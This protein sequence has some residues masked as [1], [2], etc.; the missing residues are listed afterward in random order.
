MKPFLSNKIHR[1]KREEK[2]HGRYRDAKEYLKREDDPSHLDS[3]FR[4]DLEN[5]DG[6]RCTAL[7]GRNI[8]Q[9][10]S[11]Q[12]S[13]RG[14]FLAWSND[15]SDLRTVPS[16]P[17]PAG[18]QCCDRPLNTRRNDCSLRSFRTSLL[19]ATEALIDQN[20]PEYLASPI[21][22]RDRI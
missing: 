7:R 20:I 11:T 17:G 10:L 1:S 22:N 13:R 14:N 3:C 2:E 15:R 21:P 8:E 18:L 9:R 19:H 16:H 4:Q 12:S 6:D 5:F